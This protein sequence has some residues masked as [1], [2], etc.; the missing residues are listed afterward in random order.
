MK[1]SL[2]TETYSSAYYSNHLETLKAIKCQLDSQKIFCKPQGITLYPMK[3]FLPL[4]LLVTI[5]SLF[6][7]SY[8]QDIDSLQLKNGQILTGSFIKWVNNDVTF[9]IG[10]A[11]AIDIDQNNISL[12]KG[13]SS[14]YRVETITRK[15]FYSKITSVNPGELV[16]TENGQPVTV[17]FK[18]IKYITPYEKGGAADGYIGLG[19]SHS[20]SNDFGLFNLD[21]GIEISSKKWWIEGGANSSIVYT[22]QDGFEHNREE[23]NL[24]AYLT[25]SPEWLFDSRYIYQRNVELGLAYRHAVATGFGIYAVMKPNFHLYLST[26]IAVAA[27]K[28][29]DRQSYNRLEIPL[30][31]EAEVYNLGSSNLSLKHTQTLFVGVGS[32]KRIRHDGE[33]NLSMRL[34]KKLSLTTYI[35]DNYDSAPVQKT[36][37]DNLDFGW[38]TGVRYYF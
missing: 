37:T 34:T 36:G 17:A 19:Y 1:L 16:F 3:Q 6:N 29:L 31:L 15:I 11:G 21:A 13:K 30:Y 10:G 20:Q 25:L 27:E 38:N 4:C 18:N 24:N 28:T 8:S 9:Y 7:T 33:L 23:G 5:L 32:N 22:K 2:L 26:G 12:I 35:Y 14:K